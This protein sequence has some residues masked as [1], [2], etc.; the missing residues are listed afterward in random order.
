MFGIL[1]QSIG[2]Q[3]CVNGCPRTCLQTAT[4]LQPSVRFPLSSRYAIRTRLVSTPN[5]GQL[6]EWRKIPKGSQE[7]VPK[8]SQRFPGTGLPARLPKNRFPSSRFPK[9]GSQA[10]FPSTGFP[11]KVSKQARVPKQ[12]FQE[13][14]PR[15]GSQEEVTR[16]SQRFPRTGS[17]AS[18]PKNRV[19]KQAFPTKGCQARVPRTGCQERAPRTGFAKQGLPRT[20]FASNV[21][22]AQVSREQVP[23]NRFLSKVFRNR[24]PRTGFQELVSRHRFSRTGSQARVPGTGSRQGS[25]SKQGSQERCPSKSSWNRFPSEVSKN[26]FPGTGSQEQVTKE[27]FPS[28]APRNRFASKVSRHRVPSKVYFVPTM[29]CP[30]FKLCAGPLLCVQMRAFENWEKRAAN[31]FLN[32][33]TDRIDNQRLTSA[34]SQTCFDK[35][36]V[37][38]SFGCYC[39]GYS[40]GLWDLDSYVCVYIYVCTVY[41]CVCV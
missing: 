32:C 3:I 33:R 5:V 28:K 34:S 1:S 35:H 31:N 37:I 19:F 11:S 6:F 8:D 15:T 7:Q 22:Q 12:G 23:K 21:C 38:F 29:S 30:L 14:F 24:F 25:V 4:I 39:W 26:R 10:R 2:P 27:G 16:D 40:L 41:I 18:V 13:R 17:Q 36:L 9:Q 20:G